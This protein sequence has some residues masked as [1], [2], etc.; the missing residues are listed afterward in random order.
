MADKT[1]KPKKGRHGNV[2]GKALNLVW[3]R[4][5][6]RCQLT[7]CNDDLTRHLIVGSRTAN[8][9]YVA[10]I[11]GSS[12][13]GPRGDPERSEK[14]AKDPDNV[15][16]LCDAC[17]R[18]IDREHP[19]N[20]PEDSLRAMK[21]QHEAWVSRAV[22]LSAQSQSHI[23]RFTNRIENNETAIPLDDCILAMREI[24]KTPADIHAID[25]KI[26]LTGHAETDNV[27]WAAEPG[28]LQNFFNRKFE[29]AFNTGKIRHVS[30]FGFGPMPL[31]IKLGQLIPDLH[32]IDVFARHREPTPSWTWKQSPSTFRPIVNKGAPNTKRVAIK[33][34]ITDR[35][36]D[37]RIHAVLGHNDLSIWDITCVAPGYDVLSTREDLSAFRKSIRST[38]NDIKQIHGDDAEVFVFPAAPAACCIEF[39]R[40]W[41]PKAHL[42]M[43][44]YDHVKDRGFVQRLRIE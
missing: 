42:P 41:Q 9:G 17:H 7:S 28:D 14:L 1:K 21:Q 6:G 2:T 29:G 34:S 5:A 22:G 3:A 8:K 10:H 26:G 13:D 31:L 32:D 15:M 35:I 20:Y 4:S 38:F 33:L 30:V 40:V 37:D 16:L 25:L 23:L 27:Y 12:A 11:I 24:G 36:N 43:E 19:E 39:G 44:I 18:E